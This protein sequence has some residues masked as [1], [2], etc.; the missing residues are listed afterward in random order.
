VPQCA[1]VVATAI[2][3][4]DRMQA[5]AVT[6]EVFRIT[7]DCGHTFVA[8]LNTHCPGC[9]LIRGGHT[10]EVFRGSTVLSQVTDVEA[11]PSPLREILKEKIRETTED[12]MKG[13][14]TRIRAFRPRRTYHRKQLLLEIAMNKDDQLGA[15]KSIS[16][17]LDKLGPED[18]AVVL[19]WVNQNYPTKGPSAAAPMV[20]TPAE[21]AKA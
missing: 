12:L 7:C 1:Y 18:Q 15:M 6:V 5:P 10:N 20:P 3:E 13:Q 19:E 14:E 8:S 11:T 16:K 2:M 4:M 21:P 9:G 17:N